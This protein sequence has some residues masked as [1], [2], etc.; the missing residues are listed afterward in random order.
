MERHEP[1][2]LGTA[3]HGTNRHGTVSRGLAVS[4]RLGRPIRGPLVTTGH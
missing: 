2:R 4:V 1:A 3:R